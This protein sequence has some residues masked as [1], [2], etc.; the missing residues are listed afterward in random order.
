[1]KV[2]P[3]EL[4]RRARLDL[5]LSQAELAARAGT[6]QPVVSAIENGRRPVGEAQLERLTRAAE[7]RPSIPLALYADELIEQAARLGLRNLRVF[8]SVA[9]GQDGPDSDIDL[10][11]DI[12]PG[13]DGMRAMGFSS[14]ASEIVGF[15]VDLLLSFGAVPAT[16]FERSIEHEL[17]PL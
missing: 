17:V 2:A 15:P 7:M 1:M 14:I 8:G 16:D 11:A 5:G 12:E 10:L 9:R 4:V 6:S 3:A 13:A